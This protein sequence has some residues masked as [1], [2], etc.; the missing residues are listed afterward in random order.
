MNVRRSCVAGRAETRLATVIPGVQRR[1]AMRVGRLLCGDATLLASWL[2]GGRSRGPVRLLDRT[3]LLRSNKLD[4][5][6]TSITR[7]SR[8]GRFSQKESANGSCYL[9]DEQHLPDIYL[10]HGVRRSRYATKRLRREGTG[11]TSRVHRSSIYQI[12]LHRRR[13]WRKTGFLVVESNHKL[14]SPAISRRRG[15]PSADCTSLPLFADLCSYPPCNT[16]V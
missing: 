1:S 12:S 15:I 6:N 5:P 13:Q 14:A 10:R 7:V 16:R 9:H 11:F 8:R 4:W 3:T 2:A